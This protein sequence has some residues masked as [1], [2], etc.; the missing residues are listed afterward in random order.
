MIN[1]TN[2]TY[3]TNPPNE[4]EWNGEVD[5]AKFPLGLV[6][7]ASILVIISFILIKVLGFNDKPK[8]PVYIE[9][10]PRYDPKWKR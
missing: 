9:P 4:S 1:Q 5:G 7:I 3:Q 10:K 8:K 2:Q 6:I